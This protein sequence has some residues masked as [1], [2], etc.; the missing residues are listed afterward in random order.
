MAL[1]A[2][3]FSAAGDQIPA[4]HPKILPFID[5]VKIFHFAVMP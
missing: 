4:A 5:S 1:V 2:A 3:P